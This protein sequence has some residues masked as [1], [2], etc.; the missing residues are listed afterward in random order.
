MS[1]DAEQLRYLKPEWLTHEQPDSWERIADDM[2]AE[3]QSLEVSRHD[4]DALDALRD[5]RD[6]IKAL[7]EK[8]G[9]HE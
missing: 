9:G 5:Y 7:A 2:G 4:G 3:I 6:R 1:R 8:E